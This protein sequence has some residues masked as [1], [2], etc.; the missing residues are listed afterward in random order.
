VWENPAALYLDAVAVQRLAGQ[1]VE[2]I[3]DILCI[4]RRDFRL[5]HF[6]P[7]DVY[8]D[9]G[10]RVMQVITALQRG[11]AERVVL[12]LLA[13]LPLHG[14]RTRLVTLGRPL[15]AAFP[16]PPNAVE[17]AKA[18]SKFPSRAAALERVAVAFGA[19]V[20]HGHLISGEAARRLTASGLPVLLTVHNTRAGW[21]AGLETLQAGEASLLVA[22]AN[23]VEGELRSAGMAPPIRTVRNGINLNEFQPTPARS[24]AGRQW[25]RAWGF[26]EQDFL[27]VALANPR[28][29]KRLHLL[30]QVLASLRT[31]PGLGRRARLVVC[32]EA[33]PGHPEAE[34]CV[35]Q[36]RQ[37]IARLGLE[38]DV[39]WTGPVEDVPGIL[40]SAD[41]LVSTSAHEGLSLA[42]LEALA[43]GRP[44]VA[45]DVGGAHEIAL[46]NADFHMV[47]ADA[48]AGRFAQTL[49]LLA[50]AGR[51]NGEPVPG[52]DPWSRQR[53]ASQ[54]RQLY[55]R[56]IVS[57]RNSR[58]GEGLWLITNNFS[59]GGAQ[60][61]A[62]RLLV[63]L[64]AE[65]VRVRAAVVEEQ[66][67]HPTPGRCALAKAG[68]PVLALPPADS[69]RPAAAVEALL[70]AIDND[71]PQAVLFW[72]LR[73]AYKVLLAEA[74]LDTPVLDI[75]PGEMFFESLEKYFA[76][77]RLESPFQT[78]REYGAR[79]AG[80]IVK[81][82]A[83]ARRAAE[84]LGAPVHVIPNGVS[85][86][87]ERG[88]GGGQRLV[89]GTA[90][91]INPQKRLEDLL[92]ALRCAHPHLPAYAMQIAGGVEPG[93]EDYAGR[94]RAMAEG[95]PV[96]WL[97]E[98]SDLAGFHRKLD[99]FVMISEPAGCPNASLEAM[100][101]GLPV[102][103]TAVGGAS[104]QVLDGETG[105]LVPPRD[106]EAL[107]AALVELATSPDLR[108]RIGT[109][110]RQ[111]VA[112]RFQVGRMVADYRRICLPPAPPP[113]HPLPQP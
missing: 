13:E 77:P 11:G 105:R 92:A 93:C 72:N 87:E 26:G 98:V 107:A 71:P 99:L 3:E 62:R 35:E 58:R 101:A 16:L 34:S 66:P 37:E 7:L 67:N 48:S 44:V 83:E 6:A 8:D 73:P 90:A 110:G 20:A 59:T 33:L 19:D 28:V 81:Y 112:K 39:R 86:R 74:L 109:A 60:S 30:P 12:D 85:L 95:L 84:L 23:T 25:R 61:S 2:T 104:E 113:I 40:A 41:V 70:A 32:G 69:T 96:E 91:R 17:L 1:G 55:P 75:S 57:G 56:A 108:R 64:G 14:V 78:A 65:G 24:E 102:I 103:A 47:P 111:L 52:M 27:L 68:V 94:L 89:F 82:Q 49:A 38:E 106:P 29:Q 21:P 54:Y 42:Q 31:Q 43:M 63:G 79:L 18:S 45:T 4:A 53:M 15:R 22:C 100:A 51:R 97:G 10:L 50:A 5:V 88:C 36:T 80:V 46:S 9:A 76:S